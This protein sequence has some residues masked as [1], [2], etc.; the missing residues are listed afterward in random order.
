MARYY[1]AHLNLEGRLC[2]VVG[3]GRVAE[4][5]VRSLVDCGAKVV[6][7]SPKITPG[8][9][10]LVKSGIIRHIDR[11]YREGDLRGAFLA[12]GATDDPQT[13]EAVARE[14][15]E[16]GALAN[17]VDAP[18]LCDFI[19]PAVVRRG[20]LVIGISTGGK[21]PALARKI[22]EELEEAFGPEYGIFLDILGEMRPEVMEERA[23]RAELWRRVIESDALDLIR[24][25]E[26]D[27]ARSLILSILE[28]DES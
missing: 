26:T 7:I 17:V 8:I 12:I 22:R 24:R 9:A 23:G 25:G 20:D 1:P 11:A 13:N 21:S 10:E 28:G 19:A 27:A 15:R 4:R 3:G 16:R 5:K 6:A 14:A 2:A 18:A